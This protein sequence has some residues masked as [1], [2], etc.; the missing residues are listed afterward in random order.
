MDD[1]AGWF[2]DKTHDGLGGNTFPATGLSDN[3]ENFPSVKG[4]SYIIHGFGGSLKG[5]EIGLEFVNL[6]E[7]R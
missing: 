4:E 6:K 3:A 7:M 1:L 2:R 5:V